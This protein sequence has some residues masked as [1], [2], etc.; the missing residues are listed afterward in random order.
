MRVLL[1]ICLT[2]ALSGCATKPVYYSRPGSNPEE[3]ARDGA[4]CQADSAFLPDRRNPK[5]GGAEALGEG[6]G[7]YAARENFMQNCMRAKGWVRHD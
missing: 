1:G 4:A 3:L 2:L 7:A 6:L 5:A